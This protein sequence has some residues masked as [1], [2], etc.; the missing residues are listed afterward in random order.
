VPG[1]GV[2]AIIA[3]VAVSDVRVRR[4]IW[5]LLLLNGSC[6]TLSAAWPRVNPTDAITVVPDWLEELQATLPAG[7]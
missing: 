5:C 1:P 3:R 7:Y 4:D 6:L 2:N